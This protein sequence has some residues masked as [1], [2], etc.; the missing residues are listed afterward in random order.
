MGKAAGDGQPC[1][2]RLLRADRL[3]W[4]HQGEGGGEMYL[5][6]V[7][8]LNFLVDLFLILGTNRLS[9]FAPG[10]VRAMAGAGVGAAYAAACVI[11]GWQF[12]GR[13][14]CRLCALG[15]MSLVSF[16]RGAGALRRGI[17]LSF[18]SM[19]LGGI[20][21]G[22]G[23]G[24]FWAILLGALGVSIACVVGFYGRAGQQ[25]FAAVTVFHGN[26]RLRLTALLDTGNTLCDPISGRPVMV[27]DGAYAGKLLDISPETLSDPATALA[28][29]S[30]RQLRLIPYHAVGRDGGMLLG[31]RADRVEMD[32]KNVDMIVAFAPQR[33]GQGKP[34]QALAGGN[35]I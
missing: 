32:G 3:Y 24:G 16:G 18:L 25:K 19:A 35:W 22:L 26:R 5:D 4:S 12:L 10:T 30:N 17:L 21:L 34:Y 7:V 23:N 1:C 33:I 31:L 28:G 2:D 8:I 14:A 11:P 15:V 20:A 13:T 27:I 29:L 9:G 6:L